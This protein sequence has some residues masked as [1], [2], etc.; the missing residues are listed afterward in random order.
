MITFHLGA[1]VHDIGRQY[2]KHSR[3]EENFFQ[4]NAACAYADQSSCD[5]DP[6]CSWCKSAAVKS[7]CKDINDAKALPPSIFAC[8][9]IQEEE[10]MAACAHADQTS[11]DADSAC[12]WCKSAAVKSACKDIND[13][14]ALPPSIFACDKL[15]ALEFFL[16]PQA[17]C[18]HADQSSCDADS[19]CTW[20]KSAAVK[21]ACKD[22]NDAKALPP[23]IFACDKLQEEEPKA[24]CA[25][26]DQNSCDADSACTWCKSAAV[27]S[28]C[29]DINDAKALP[30]SIFACDKLS[31]LE[32]FLAPQAACAHADQNSC[33]ADSACTWCKSAAVKSACKDINDAKALPPS[34]FACD[35][36]QLEAKPEP[37]EKP[38]K[39]ISAMDAFLQSNAACAHADQN[40]CDADSACTWCKS[41]AVK[42]ACKDINDAKA[43]PPSIF[44]CD[45]LQ[46]EEFFEPEPRHGHHHRKHE[47]EPEDDEDVND[48][49]HNIDILRGKGPKGPKDGHG[50]RHHLSHK[51]AGPIVLLIVV[52]AHFYFMKKFIKALEHKETLKGESNDFE[53]C[54]WR[55]GKKQGKKTEVAQPQSFAPSSSP[56]VMPVNNLQ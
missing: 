26:A 46:D 49:K 7:A 40:S 51:A 11:C 16:A 38:V 19:A 50:P 43:L 3:G 37:V 36:I 42:S 18:A 12:T 22:I 39:L 30:P 4:P 5:A 48:M 23:S 21:S 14:K 54:P 52:I 27:K 25:H 55:K 1:R 33:D 15:T 56:I 47:E 44:A 29:K 45:K 10:P 17:A 20:C 6:A 31:A 28:A 34:I 8:D 41:A 53:G 9:K 35:K 24:A 13:A 32:Y 2:R